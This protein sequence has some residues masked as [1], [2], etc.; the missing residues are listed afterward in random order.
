M[1]KLILLSLLALFIFTGKANSQ[2][3]V[4][5]SNGVDGSYTS[6]TNAG[7]MFAAF[8]ASP[9]QVGMNITVSITGDVLTEGGVYPLIERFWTSMTI[10]PSGGAARTIS[11]TFAGNMINLNGADNV[12][13][14]GLNSGGNSLTISNLSTSGAASTIRFIADA[15]NNTVTNCT[16]SGSSTDNTTGT[17]VFSTGTT[18]GNISNNIN[19][20]NIGPA[21][22]NLPCQGIYS[23]GTS[24]AIP[25]TVTVNAN[26]IFDYFHATLGTH[27]I[28]LTAT[29]NTGWT[30][31]NNRLY[32]TAN[33][34]FTTANTHAGIRI[35]TG[36]GYTITG[37]VIGFANS[38]GT[39]TTNLL[40]ITSGALTGTFPSAYLLGTATLNATRYMA[41]RLAFTAGGTVSSIQNNTIGG[42]ALL[43]SSGATAQNGIWCAINV[44]S[45]NVNIGTSTGNTIGST[46]G[47]SSVYTASSTAGGTAVGIY[48]LSVNTVTIQNNTI[49]AFDCSGT[50]ASTAQSFTGIDGAG[51]AGIFTISSNTIGNT[52]A[53]NMRSGYLT[54][55]GISGG[56]LTNSAGIL[57]SATG[58]SNDVGI[59]TSSNGALSITGNTFRGWNIGGT[60]TTCF[61]ILSNGAVTTSNTIDGNFLGTA[62]LG[63]VR[64]TFTNSGLLTGISASATSAAATLSISTNDF[65]GIVNTIGG[66]QAQTYITV[67]HATSTT[68]TIN[69]NTFTNLAPNFSGSG[70]F[71]T[72]TGN[73]TATGTAKTINNS[74]VTGYN[75]GAIGGGQTTVYAASA[76]SVTGS[77]CLDTN[78]NFSNITLA[79]SSAF[80]GWSNLD[81]LSTSSGPTKVIRGNVISN[82][83][84]GSGQY[85]GISI[86][87]TGTSLTCVN[88]TISGLTCTA[89]QT[90]GILIGASNSLTGT[91]NVSH[92][93]ILNIEG[94]NAAGLVSGMLLRS[95]GATLNVFNNIVG[96]L[97]NPLGSNGTTDV[98]RG[99]S[100]TSDIAS[101]TINLSN[102]TVYLNAAAGG[103]NFTTSA[104]YVTTQAVATTAALVSR[105]NIFTNVSLA[106]GTGFANAYRRSSTTLTNFSATSNKNN[107]YSAGTGTHNLFFDETN[108]VTTIGAYTTLVSPADANSFSENTT[109]KST[110]SAS[111]DFMKIDETVNTQCESNGIVVS[112]VTDDFF[113]TP[114][115]PNVGFPENISTPAS[116][117]DIGAYEFGLTITAAGSV[118]IAAGTYTNAVISSLS[119][120]TNLNG[121]TINGVL[122]IQSGTGP[123]TGAITYGPGATIN[124]TGSGSYTTGSEIT[125]TVPNIIINNSGGVVLNSSATISNLLTL[126]SGTLTVGANTLTLSGSSP[127]R[128]SGN[129]DA[130]NAS[131]TV[132]FTNTG[133]ITLP[134]STFTGNVKNLTVSGSGGSVALGQSLTITGTVTVGTGATLTLGA[135]TLTGS[136][137]TALAG[138][139]TIAMT[140]ELGTQLSSFTSNT[141]RT[142]GTYQFNGSGAQTIPADTYNNLYCTNTSAINLGGNVTIDGTLTLISGNGNLNIGANT[143]TISNPIAGTGA[144]T[145]LVGGSTSNLTING[146]TPGINIPGSVTSLNNLNI[147]NSQIVTGGTSLVINGTLTLEATA[148]FLNMGGNTLTIGTSTSNTGS[149]VRNG[150][151]I[152]GTLR[153]WFASG[154]SSDNIFPLDNGT[155]AFSQAKVTFNSLTTGGTLTATFNNSGSGS[156]P[157]QGNGFYLPT[158]PSMGNVNLINLA[159]QYWTITA[160]DGLASPNYNLELI[161]DA[162][163]N[164]S[165]IDYIAIIKRNDGA[166]P[167]TWSSANYSVTTG[168]NT[169]PVLYYNG[170]TSFSDFGVG[171]NV[172]NLLPV[173]LSSFTASIDK[174][175]VKLNWTT[176]HELNNRGF[177][178]ERK[179]SSEGW[180]KIGYAEGH[181][182][183]NELQNYS[184]TDIGLN[185]GNYNYR[186]KQIDY[187][188][189]FGYHDLSGEVIIGIPSKYSLAQN[190]PNPFNPSTIINYQLAVNSFVSLKVYDMTG[191]EVSSLVNEVKNAGYYSVT[192]DAKNLSSGIY[193]YSIQAGD[194]SNTKKMLLVK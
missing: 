175:N 180:E 16:I 82:V 71:I 148:G 94:S 97:R 73:M 147:S 56:N 50:T 78:N 105:N 119:T 186:L 65:R 23:S 122:T 142:S 121:C 38:S 75:K 167:W 32:Q 27:G 131:S 137:T 41:F 136:G 104:L 140:G 151:S 13:F 17:V 135:N 37:N 157:N 194:F 33:R 87:S 120:A 102:N 159:P 101:T 184:F 154:A 139:G 130:S 8:N 86:N 9:S 156:L 164:I 100:I 81:G 115:Y 85:L 63:W 19:N 39:G 93:R 34:I 149:I 113:Y 109:F 138:S 26:N 28:Y 62:G 150:G 171:G 36:E 143:L 69:G 107:Y 21:G 141:F 110:S 177:E 132:A 6:L 128:T 129:I 88:N 66:T 60:A 189:N 114:R 117:P 57:V 144:S 190:Y 191:K 187:N 70:T 158:G 152:R 181:G 106:Q 1:K 176:S 165:I 89:T 162:I 55:T 153:R 3:T 67:N 53:D 146:S 123:I 2:I 155:G 99:I 45:G 24:L 170:G 18:T 40:G 96:D 10:S 29:G 183:T 125:G 30:I 111:A 54:A 174:Q 83:S 15:S 74:I 77:A 84:G 22:A 80:T 185:T 79:G 173:E 163:P 169:N 46:T 161:G 4:T 127:V 5:G 178:I 11:G 134:A 72:R 124:Y 166:S 126:T 188:G 172:D 95:G 116:A 91:Y 192:F 20:C 133:A 49:G 42:F 52:T 48:T 168:T 51:G 92:N 160:G 145:L 118:T 14:N 44:N 59:R 108:S 103:T 35:E 43:T 182:T 76:N 12:T 25:N 7:G 47:Q 64:Y 61:G 98:I 58:T 68:S 179:S 31:T 90:I 193:F 112:G